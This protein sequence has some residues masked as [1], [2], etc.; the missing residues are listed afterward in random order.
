MMGVPDRILAA[1]LLAGFALFLGFAKALW[2]LDTPSRAMPDTAVVHARGRQ[3]ALPALPED[4]A[5]TGSQIGQATVGADPE[6]PFF[7]GLNSG[8]AGGG[9]SLLDPVAADQ[10]S[11]PPALPPVH[12]API[13]AG[14]PLNA[15][16]P[17]LSTGARSEPIE[18]GEPRATED[19]TFSRGD[20]GGYESV[21]V[22]PP[23]DAEGPGGSGFAG[24]RLPRSVGLPLDADRP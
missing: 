21:T 24:D 6:V 15:D 17:D 9:A 12:G 11:G 4:A 13:E 1:R 23:L 19:D 2:T 5:S 18:I 14:D 7:R 10:S 16:D 8:D 3:E 20:G 22:G